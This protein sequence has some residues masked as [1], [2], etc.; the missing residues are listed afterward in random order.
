MI[1]RFKL[2]RSIKK[3]MNDPNATV[4]DYVAVFEIY[5]K[6]NLRKLTKQT[7]VSKPTANMVSGAIKSC[8][9]AHGPITS[10][11]IGSATKRIMGAIGQK[12]KPT[13][14]QKIRKLWKRQK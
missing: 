1:K 14:I 3:V 13:I 9:S 4:E 8:I 12:P 6:N 10:Q 11:L 7:L 5:E 2:C